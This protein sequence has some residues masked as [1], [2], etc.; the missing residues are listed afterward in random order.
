M[1]PNNESCD[2]AVLPSVELVGSTKD[3][4]QV[5]TKSVAPLGSTT[6]TDASVGESQV[7]FAV[8]DPTLVSDGWRAASTNG[9]FTLGSLTRA[10]T[11]SVGTVS[12]R[13]TRAT[14]PSTWKSRRRS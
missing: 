8:A 3:S 2:D 7:A 1:V 13:W 12:S 5:P 9:S 14:E 4:D 11:L 10:S 6:S